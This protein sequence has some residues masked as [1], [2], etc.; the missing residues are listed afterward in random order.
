MGGQRGAYAPLLSRLTRMYKANSDGRE[1][2]SVF[3]PAH[4]RDALIAAGPFAGQ[5]FDL[6]GGWRDAGDNLKFTQTTGLAVAALN[7][8]ARMAPARAPSCAPPATWACAGC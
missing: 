2:S 8:A 7:Y 5:R 1:P 6:T 3:G 4:L